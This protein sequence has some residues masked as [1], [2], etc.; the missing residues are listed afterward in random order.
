MISCEEF[1]V[2]SV[3]SHGCSWEQRVD[4]TVRDVTCFVDIEVAVTAGLKIGRTKLIC[5]H[6]F[7]CVQYM[8]TDYFSFQHP[9]SPEIRLR[10][11]ISK[12]ISI[13]ALEFLIS[14]TTCSLVR[15]HK[16]KLHWVT[17]PKIILVVYS[18]VIGMFLIPGLNSGGYHHPTRFATCSSRVLLQS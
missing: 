17:A 5:N 16:R 13:K 2:F 7:V 3:T 1:K 10:S 12:R 9:F 4:S 18:A 14:R 11:Q 8:M 15:C 6:R